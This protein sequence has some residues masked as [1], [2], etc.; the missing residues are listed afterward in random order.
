MKATKCLATLTAISLMTSAHAQSCGVA[1]GFSLPDAG[2]SRPVR[3]LDKTLVFRSGLRV[4]TDGAANSYHPVGTSKGALNTICNGIAVTPRS[5]KWAN[6]RVTGKHPDR[7]IREE[8]CQLILDVFRRSQAAGYAILPDADIDWYAL[9]SRSPEAGKYR[10][11]VQSTGP[12]S[13]FFVAQTARAADPAKDICDPAHWI[14]ST[15]IPYITLPGSNL[16]GQGAKAGDLALVHRRR[17]N[18]DYIVV[19]VAGDTGNSDELGEGSLAL[20]IA[21]G[22]AATAKIPGNIPDNVTT[23]LFPGRRA[24]NPITATALAS[25]RDKLMNAIG[26][27]N[28]L[29]ACVN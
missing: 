22:N 23:I 5:G 8:R 25:E 16:S 1:A 6:K 18:V 21:L 20:H 2:K 9:A 13:G 28:T 11:C 14:S 24:P 4:N 12:F 29:L 17:G 26:G 7:A 27:K 3:R 19:A 10:P 15:E